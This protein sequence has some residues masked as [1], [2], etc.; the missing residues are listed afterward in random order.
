MYLDC[1]N[2]NFTGEVRSFIIE[3]DVIIALMSYINP[4]HQSILPNITINQFLSNIKIVYILIIVSKYDTECIL[5][6][7]L[8]IPFNYKW[9]PF[10]N[11]GIIYIKNSET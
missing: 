6:I 2:S 4:E 3:Q 11:L 10:S 8:Y 5:N 9:L 1:V 7:N